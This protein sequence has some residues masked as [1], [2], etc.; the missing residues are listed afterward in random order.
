[1]KKD[2]IFAFAVNQSNT[3]EKTHFGD[4]EKFLIYKWIDKHLVF[5]EMHTNQS[6]LID[7]KHEHG[8]ETKAALII[9]QLVKL[10]V[11]VI[12][13]NQFGKNI[14]IVNSHFIPVVIRVEKPNQIIPIF[15][16]NMQQFIDEF[17]HKEKVFKVFSVLNNEVTKIQ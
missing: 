2:L 7:E 5:Q 1:M 16:L 3:F 15:E 13:S 9:E 12:V 10:N 8:S 4:A 17:N 11:N 14:R 6:K